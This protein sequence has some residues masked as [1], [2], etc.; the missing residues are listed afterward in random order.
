LKTKKNKIALILDAV[1]GL[2]IKDD[3]EYEQVITLLVKEKSDEVY[4]PIN[5]VI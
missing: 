4:V 5:T 1:L 3:K 2:D